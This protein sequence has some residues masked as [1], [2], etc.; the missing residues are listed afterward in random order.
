MEKTRIELL[1]ETLAADPENA[2]VRYG[3]ALELSNAGRAPEAWDHFNYLLT[4][5]PDYAATYYQAGV[6]LTKQGRREEAATVFSRGIEVTGRLGN[7]HAQSEL[8]AAL[9][10][11]SG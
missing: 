6:F 8:Q 10:D 9:D 1:S 4:H 2:F 11:L 7:S 5:H 3:L